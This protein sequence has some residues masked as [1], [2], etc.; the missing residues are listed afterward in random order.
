MEWSEICY[1]LGT[2]PKAPLP[3]N[4]MQLIAI[5][6]T[7]AFTSRCFATHKNRFKYVWVKEKQVIIKWTLDL[8]REREDL[9]GGKMEAMDYARD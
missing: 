3:V 1:K 8:L 4:I 6:S 7:D 5:R 9:S 2:K